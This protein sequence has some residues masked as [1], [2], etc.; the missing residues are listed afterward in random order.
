MLDSKLEALPKSLQIHPLYDLE[1]LHVCPQHS[2]PSF[3]LTIYGLATLK[4]LEFSTC[5]MFFLLDFVFS[6]SFWNTFQILYWIP[7]IWIIYSC[8]Q[9]PSSYVNTY[10]LNTL[11]SHG[12]K[13]LSLSNLDTL[14]LTSQRSCKLL[15]YCT[16]IDIFSWL[17][18]SLVF[19][20]WD[21]DS[22]TAIVTGLDK[23]QAANRFFL[24][25]LN[26]LV[27]VMNFFH[28][29]GREPIY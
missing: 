20:L 27:S 14:Y 5:C 19:E 24:I 23:Q 12:K 1:K 18:S 28:F 13:A 16:I 9:V 6:P 4:C 29:Q 25:V 15:K 26:L 3:S 17:Y 22:F 2:Y 8:S 11:P 7:F 21:M 10:W